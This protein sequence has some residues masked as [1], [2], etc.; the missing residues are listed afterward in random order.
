[1]AKIGW[2]RILAGVAAVAAGGAAYVYFRQR[3]ARA[4]IYQTLLADGGFEIR[5]YPALL[6]IETIQHGSRDRALGAGFALLSA[7]MYGEARDGE[8]IPMT[9]PFLAEPLMAGSGTRDWR[10]RFLIPEGH[11]AGS[12]PPPGAGIAIVE[13]PAQEMAAV[14]IAGQ[15]SDRSFATNTKSLSGWLQSHE[16]RGAGAGQ[17]AYYNS[18]LMPGPLRPNEVLIPLE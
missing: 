15:P 6:A 4:P 18:P 17:Q 7:Y 1:M 5:R 3:A 12:L 13:I 10:I 11:S 9:L 2:G 8:E 16:R 14:K